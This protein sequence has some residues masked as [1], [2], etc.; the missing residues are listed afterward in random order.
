MYNNSKTKIEVNSFNYILPH[1]QLET[2]RYKNDTVFYFQQLFDMYNNYI[3]YY[4]Y[5]LKQA[6]QDFFLISVQS[7]NYVVHPSEINCKQ[8][9]P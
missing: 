7:K 4:T 6:K 5:I 8:P 2:I 1:K 3:H 9:F